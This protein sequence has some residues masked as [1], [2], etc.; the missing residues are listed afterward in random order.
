MRIHSASRP[1]NEGAANP[2]AE[3]ALQ[4]GCFLA[5]H[6]YCCVLDGG[7]IVLDVRD[8]AYLGIEARYIP[9]LRARVGNWPD[10]DRSDRELS[11][12]DRSAIEIPA[13][14]I[15]VSELIARGI[16]TTSPGSDRPSPAANPRAASAFTAS[17]R[18]WRDVSF[19]DTRRFAVALLMVVLKFRKRRL[20]SL[21][22]WLHR[23]QSS[24][25]VQ[26]R[27]NR[28]AVTRELNSF[29]W[30]RTWCY[31]ASRHCLFDSLI[32]S[33][34]LTKASIP[35]TLVIGVATRPFLA[36]AWVQIGESVLNDT[37]EHA[38]MFKPILSI[39]GG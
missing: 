16:L 35:C 17:S 10:A 26:P 2:L 31:T 25:H 15:L 4:P 3:P 21:L 5:D 33:I 39:G 14:K 20:Q 32:L 1:A 11:H 27:S 13:L 36:H 37:A 30:L 9:H 18:S 8:D 6:A 23:H 12:G 22:G 34:Y 7:A 19:A 29:L 38:Y 28:E 24:L